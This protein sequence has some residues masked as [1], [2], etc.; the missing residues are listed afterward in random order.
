MVL[1]E[2]GKRLL[3]GTTA[4]AAGEFGSLFEGTGGAVAVAGACSFR[5]TPRAQTFPSSVFVGRGGFGARGSVMG[6]GR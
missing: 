3:V 1:L 2:S 6:R 5:A 4:A